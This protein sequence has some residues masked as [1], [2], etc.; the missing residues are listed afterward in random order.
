M[1]V[2]IRSA[3]LVLGLHLATAAPAAAQFNP[4]QGREYRE[5]TG[6]VNPVRGEALLGLAVVPADE[7]PRSQTVEVWLPDRFTGELQVETLSA[8]GRFRGEGAYRGTSEGGRWVTLSVAP[9]N[10]RS[11]G[12]ASPRPG[13]S[14]TL[15][16][17]VRG[18]NS[19]LFVARWGSPTPRPATRL[20]FY[21]NS[22]RADVSV[23]AGAMT[24]PCTALKI[25]QPLRFDAYCDVA[26]SDILANGSV[27]LIRRDLF[28][29]ETQPLTVNLR[30]IR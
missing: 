9:A 21:V 16:L 22:R 7:A 30:G 12:S 26:T 14:A 13:D 18:P 24:V 3:C 11:A 17:A 6:M 10:A 27:V 1:T 19:T 20:R 5:F 28:D 2:R 23:R 29:E 8:D 25:P 4:V 15:A